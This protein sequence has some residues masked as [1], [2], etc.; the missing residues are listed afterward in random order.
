ESFLQC[1]GEFNGNYQWAQENQETNYVLFNLS[2]ITRL[3]KINFTYM[4]ESGNQE[5]K[6]SFCTV[7][8]SMSIGSAFRNLEC[9][10]VRVEATGDT[11]VGTLVPSFANKTGKIGMEVI[12][13]GIKAAFTAT[14]VE[15]FGSCT[16]STTGNDAF[17]VLCML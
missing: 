17:D 15:F 12:T 2:Q 5:P 1:D 9:Q 7:P 4:V 10:E 14:R 16:V 3:S 6:I 13:Q 8:A 11:V